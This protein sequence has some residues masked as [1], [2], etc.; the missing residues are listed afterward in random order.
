MKRINPVYLFYPVIFLFPPVHELGHVIIA[1]ICGYG[2]SAGYWNHVVYH[3]TA[4]GTYPYAFL[5]SWWEYSYWIAPA[6]AIIYLFL[7][8]KDMKVKKVADAI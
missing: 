1:N 5:Q 3:T 4:A 2:I 6:C 8:I 7:F